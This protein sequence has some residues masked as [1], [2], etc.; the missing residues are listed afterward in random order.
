MLCLRAEPVLKI[1]IRQ[2]GKPLE[3]L[4]LPLCAN[5]VA[6]CVL[7][8]FACCWHWQFSSVLLRAAAL[9][10]ALSVGLYLLYR[11]YQPYDRLLLRVV[12]FAVERQHCRANQGGSSSVGS[13]SLC[14]QLPVASLLL[15]RFEAGCLFGSCFFG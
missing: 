11:C 7:L 2:R 14:R 10:L 13:S 12:R 6:R 9:P 1:L 5:G 15:P 3:A 4:L 8:P